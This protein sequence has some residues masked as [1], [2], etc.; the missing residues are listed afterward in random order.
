M[1][2]SQPGRPHRRVRHPVADARA[3]SIHNACRDTLR[4]SAVVTFLAGVALRSAA[5]N[6]PNRA[7][8]NGVVFGATVLAL[9]S[10]LPRS[11]RGSSRTPRRPSTRDGRHFWWQMRFS[12]VFRVADWFCE[13][14]YCQQPSAIAWLASLSLVLTVVYVGSVIV[15]PSRPHRLEPASILALL[16]Y[17]VGIIGLIRIVGEQGVVA[18]LHLQ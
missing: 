9:A 17:V 8:I 10:A 16:F 11:V 6:W 2:G 13:N 3:P 15:R 1:A 12:Y 14:P 18:L 5:T 7:G 4:C